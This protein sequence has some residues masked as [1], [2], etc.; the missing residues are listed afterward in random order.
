MASIAWHDDLALG[1]AQL[2][3]EH[4]ELIALVGDVF[5]TADSSRDGE[6]TC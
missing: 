3:Q 4:R 6:W 1:V 5:N 2:D